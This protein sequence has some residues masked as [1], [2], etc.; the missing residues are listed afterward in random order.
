MM[1]Y[2]NQIKD[3]YLYD[4]EVLFS[5]INILKFKIDKFTYTL[6]VGTP[7]PLKGLAQLI[8]NNLWSKT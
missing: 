8:Y 4:N 6:K 5:K 1:Y 2:F 3:E 7:Q